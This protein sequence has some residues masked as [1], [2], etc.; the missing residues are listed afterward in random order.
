MSNASVI[1]TTIAGKAQELNQG[2]TGTGII[3]FSTDGTAPMI[4]HL[5]SVGT[6]HRRR[7]YELYRDLAVWNVCHRQRQHDHR[8]FHGTRCEL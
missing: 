5:L 4:N 3:I 7:H 6:S 2:G 8:S 1:S